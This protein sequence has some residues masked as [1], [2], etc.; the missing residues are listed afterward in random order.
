MSLPS[1]SFI[2]LNAKILVVR[3]TLKR[4]KKRGWPKSHRSSIVPA[5]TWLNKKLINVGVLFGNFAFCPLKDSP[6]FFASRAAFLRSTSC[7][8]RKIGIISRARS[9]DC[10]LRI[11]REHIGLHDFRFEVHVSSQSDTFVICHAV[12]ILCLGS[13]FLQDY[14]KI[15]LALILY[16]DA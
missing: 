14:V 13:F 1:A 15:M 9:F 5:I 11:F 4:E 6:P 12:L 8:V 3:T 7:S 10:V 2:F 16:C